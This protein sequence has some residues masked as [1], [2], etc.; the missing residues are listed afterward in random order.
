MLALIMLILSGGFSH[1]S[2]FVPTR[3]NNEKAGDNFNWINCIVIT[4]SIIHY[5]KYSYNKTSNF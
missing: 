4:T 1:V 2:L 3:I 5:E